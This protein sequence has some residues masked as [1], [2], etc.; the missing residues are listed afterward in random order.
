MRER[1]KRRKRSNKDVELFEVHSRGLPGTWGPNERLLYTLCV[2]LVQK[3]TLSLPTVDSADVRSGPNP[4]IW[5]Q[6][7]VNSARGASNHPVSPSFPLFLERREKAARGGLMPVI[8]LV[9]GDE[10]GR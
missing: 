8:S 2:R 10:N 3:K 7:S 5:P 9:G 4:S 1:R 6:V